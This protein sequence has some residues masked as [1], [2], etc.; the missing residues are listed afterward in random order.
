VHRCRC[1][2]V[3]TDRRHSGDGWRA[4]SYAGCGRVGRRAGRGNRTR[5]ARRK[6]RA[7]RAREQRRHQ[8]DGAHRPVE[9]SRLAAHDRREPRQRVPDVAAVLA[10]FP[11]ARW[12]RH[13]QHLLH[14]GAGRRHR[15]AGL[16]R[17]Q[18]RH[19]H[20][21]QMPGQ[22]WGGPRHPRQRDLPGVHRHAAAATDHRAPPRSAHGARAAA[23]AAAHGQVRHSG[24]YCERGT[25]PLPAGIGFHQRDRA[26]ATQ[27]D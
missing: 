1:R 22:G 24:G 17:C 26:D 20:A 4:R 13:S 10:A 16:L 21:E 8:H 7:G 12:R 27:I 15:R 5:R 11:G 14:H 18:G 9:R 3:E 6:G 23:R 19:H 25:F 2:G